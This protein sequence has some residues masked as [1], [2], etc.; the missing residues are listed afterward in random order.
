MLTLFQHPPSHSGW[1]GELIEALQ[2]ELV[3]TESASRWMLK[4]VQHDGGA[5]I[6]P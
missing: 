2:Q 6:T 1:S 4:Q 5:F 3:G